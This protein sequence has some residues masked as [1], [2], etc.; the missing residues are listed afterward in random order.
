MGENGAGKSTLLKV[1]TGVY[2]PE[3]G[4][5]VL[6][7][8][9]ITPSSPADAQQLG[10]SMVYQ[11]VNLVPHLS[12]AENI[13][14]GRQPRTMGV[15][16]HGAMAKRARNAMGRLGLDLDVSKS[17]SSCSIAIQ[18]MV[19]IARAVDIEAK[20]LVLDEPTSSLDT[21][22]VERLYEVMRRLRDNGL[23]LVF[24][25]H[26]LDQVYEITDR[27]TVLR[28]GGLVGEWLTAD[29]P[30]NAL[31]AKMLGREE[32]Q[33]GQ[34]SDEE[35]QSR[36]DAET[37]L[38]RSST[39]PLISIENG[40][41]RHA[42]AD[43]NFKVYPGE[44]L[45]LAGL[46]GSGRTETARL[47]YGADKP[48]TGTWSAAGRAGRIKTPRQAMAMGFGF[49]PEDRKAEGIIPGLSIRE[50]MILALQCRRGWFRP[51]SRKTQKS[52]SQKYISALRIATPDAEKQ[53]QQLSGGNQQKVILARW[54]A[55][56]PKL[57][58]LDEPTRGIDVGA[59]AEIEALVH[60]LRNDGMA[61]VF[62]SS[63]LEETLRLADRLVMLRD[64]RQVA[65]LSGDEITG[66]EVM[67]L[68]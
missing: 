54:L 7:G 47:I 45:G 4:Q 42:V 15:I 34:I 44:T 49:C 48:S 21:N 62:I 24:V 37:R 68:L 41:R 57:L 59:K 55:A 30:R 23:G 29:L 63:E 27:I 9:Q 31:V 5:I 43:L 38:D 6:G 33:F 22:E 10:I 67:K 14:L 1:L 65:I 3:D 17:L 35:E 19:A 61:V 26:F 32:S 53:I 40:G 46:L 20:V 28:N 16:R 51:V 52:I 8:T 12:V 39:A 50:N 66:A 11:E 60:Q 36:E 2:K 58:L 25:T 13:C 64:G 56:D 18:Q